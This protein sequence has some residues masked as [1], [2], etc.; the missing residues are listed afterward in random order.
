MTDLEKTE[1]DRQ[2]SERL[3]VEKAL[4][5]SE[6]RHTPIIAMTAQAMKGDR[7]R[8][9]AAGMDDYVSKPVSA[10]SLREVLRK[11]LEGASGSGEAPGSGT[12]GGEPPQASGNAPESR[13]AS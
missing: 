11:H 8:C 3:R 4:Q 13:G 6:E 12:P 7:E 2:I 5:A 1:L 10:A 9:L